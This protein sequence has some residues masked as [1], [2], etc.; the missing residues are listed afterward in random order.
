L[1]FANPITPVG[2]WLNPAQLKNV[3][4]AKL[5]DTFLVLDEAYCEFTRSGDY[6]SGDRVLKPSD[7]N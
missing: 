3:I 4:A 7:G 2:C 6:V 5:P 1:I